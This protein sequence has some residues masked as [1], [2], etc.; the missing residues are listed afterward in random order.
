MHKQPDFSTCSRP[1]FISMIQDLQKRVA[2]LEV[3]VQEKVVP[4]DVREAIIHLFLSIG[5]WTSSRWDQHLRYEYGDEKTD[6]I[7]SWL[8]AEGILYEHP[9]D[10]W[11]GF[12][13]EGSIPPQ[14][15]G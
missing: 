11:A 13:P 10:A 12:E 7:I 14:E 3:L 15:A 8:I 9:K 6:K 2:E 1:I 4:E 5:S